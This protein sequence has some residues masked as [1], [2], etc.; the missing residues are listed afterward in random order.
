MIIYCTHVYVCIL[1]IY[2][3]WDR[4]LTHQAVAVASLLDAAPGD[5]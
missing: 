5:S 1:Y 4:W 3:Y 2:I